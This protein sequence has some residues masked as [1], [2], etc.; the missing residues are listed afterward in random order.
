MINDFEELPFKDVSYQCKRVFFFRS[1]KII[2][3][4]L[5][6]KKRRRIA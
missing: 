5:V 4:Y 2:L 6:I 1:V 3:Y